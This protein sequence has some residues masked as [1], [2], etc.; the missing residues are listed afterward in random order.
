M[1]SQDAP[2]TSLPH[3]PF[4]SAGFTRCVALLLPLPHK[5][6]RPIWIIYEHFS[7]VIPPK[8]SQAA[9][10]IRNALPVF[11]HPCQPREGRQWALSPALRSPPCLLIFIFAWTSTFKSDISFHSYLESILQH[12]NMNAAPKK[13]PTKA[14]ENF[15]PD[16]WFSQVESK[17]PRRQ[18]LPPRL[19]R[20]VFQHA[21]SK[22]KSQSTCSG[23]CSATF[24]MWTATAR[25]E[26]HFNQWCLQKRHLEVRQ[27]CLGSWQESLQTLH[28]QRV[29]I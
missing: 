1:Q 2:C 18:Y 25:C 11:P 22:T 24:K 4:T 3:F 9:T 27:W 17:K 28:Y 12:F 8:V 16:K 29:S 14:G 26:R 23:I 19:Y 21:L 7:Q 10:W 6:T 13:L 5:H 15:K 20:E